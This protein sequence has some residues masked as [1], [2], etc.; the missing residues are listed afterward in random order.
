MFANSFVVM[1]IA[2]HRTLPLRLLLPKVDGIYKTVCLHCHLL[3]SIQVIAAVFYTAGIQ[4]RITSIISWY[5]YLS[6][7]LRNTWLNFILDRYFHYLL[8]YSMLLPLNG[9]WCLFSQ[10][11]SGSLKVEPVLS[12]ATVCRRPRWSKTMW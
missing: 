12:P 6:L 5:L 2:F 10:R 7:S 9:C 8:F 3:L 1:K 11:K 4:T